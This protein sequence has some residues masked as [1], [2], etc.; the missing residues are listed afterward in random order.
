MTPRDTAVA[1]MPQDQSSA[2]RRVLVV[3]NPAAGRGRGRLAEIL[4]RVAGAGCAVTV[5][6]TGGPGDATRIVRHEGPLYD[7]VAV[8]GGDGT[9]N[10]AANG[11]AELASPPML[12][13]IPRGTAN[14]LAWEIG[15]GVDPVRAAHAI[16]DGPP[17]EIHLGRVNGRHFLLMAGV[18]FDAAV[19]AGVGPR[20]KR[21]LG[22][23]AYV[24][25]TVVELFRYHYPMFDVSIDGVP[26]RAASVVVAKAHFYGGRFVCAPEARLTDPTFEV[27]LF[28]RGGSW[29]AMRYAAALALGRLSRL[30][31]IKIVRGRHVVIGSLGAAADNEPVQVDGERLGGLPVDITVAPRRLSLLMPGAPNHR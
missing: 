16:A 8:A 14:V 4:R 27:C 2:A 5:R 17:A 22:K 10:E 19:V 1:A 31:T 30:S 20:L 15:L 25:R 21:A 9:I 29:H 23:F 3:V 12:A 7:V 26:Y 28:L 24:W 18:G 13:V 11:L 6:E